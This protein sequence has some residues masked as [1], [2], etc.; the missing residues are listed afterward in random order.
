MAELNIRG[1]SVL[2][3][4]E[5]VGL[6]SQHTWFFTKQGY[7][8][9]SVRIGVNKRRT[10]GM[11]R[12]LLGDPPFPSIDHINRNKRDN[13]KANLRACTD[14]ENSLNKDFSVIRRK[15]SSKYWGVSFN[16]R[17]HWQVVVK[18]NG[19]AQHFGSFPIEEVAAKK[20]KEVYLK[21]YGEDAVYEVFPK[22]QPEKK[23]RIYKFA[24]SGI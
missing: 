6:V 18:I 15:G 8:C 7:A 23:R 4:D 22:E 1:R 12:I 9:T 16:K 10:M 13:R 3:D 14:S 11:H 17:G 5:D 20:A 24:G 19:K 21:I 2:V